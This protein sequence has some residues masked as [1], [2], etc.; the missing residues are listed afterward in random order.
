MADDQDEVLE[1][2]RANGVPI[3]RANYIEVAWGPL[4]PLWDAAME[5]GLPKGLQDWSLFKSVGGELVLKRPPKPPPYK[6]PQGGEVPS[7]YDSE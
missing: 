2:M 5:S 3:T 6:P 4:P 1:L 7:V